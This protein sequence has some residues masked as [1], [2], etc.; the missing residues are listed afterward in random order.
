[1]KRALFSTI[2]L[3]LLLF[4]GTICRA[5]AAG[6]N[7]KD[8]LWEMTMETR[9]EGL[10]FAMPPVSVTVK[11]CISKSDP[12][13]QDPESKKNCR[14]K[15]QKVSGNKVSWEFECSQEEGKADGKGEMTYS[16]STSSGVSKVVMTTKEGEKMTSTTKIK[17]KRIEACPAGG[18]EPAV[19][20]NGRDVKKEAKAI[21]EQARKIEQMT[22]QMQNEQ[23]A[24]RR[25]AEEIIRRAKVPREKDDACVY[26]DESGVH[27][28]CEDRW[29]DIPIRAGEWEIT[30][31]SATKTTFGSMLNLSAAPPKSSKDCLSPYS[32]FGSSI[33]Q[34]G[35]SG[36]EVK[37]RSGNT[38]TWKS[39]DN[40][41]EER[42]GI[43]FNGD[44]YQGGVISKI[45]FEE[46]Y[47]ILKGRRIGD[48]ECVGRDY[49][50]KRERAAARKAKER[51][52]EP[53]DKA[54]KSGEPPVKVINPVREL[55]SLFGL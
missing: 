41:R 17:G 37:M 14:I 10:P 52:G 39:V 23:E 53:A 5:V 16:G 4:C 50:A 12:I 49:T 47:T 48:G 51:K 22:A 18:A 25:R 9:M 32:F 24:A 42:G 19:L 2:F 6:P 29:G 38:V 35:R 54:T 20:V 40:G 11:Q 8:G 26:A 3:A 31:E 46:I 30:E 36:G 1:M 21:E 33:S 7:I 44:S 27:L 13:L 43:E 34:G 45:G 55:R 28:D 15:N